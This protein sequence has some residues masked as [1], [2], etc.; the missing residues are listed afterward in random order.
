M[1]P[2]KQQA[3]KEF[4][5]LPGVTRQSAGRLYDAG[6]GSLKELSKASARD[7]YSQGMNRQLA[8]NIESIL[9][10]WKRSGYKIEVSEAVR[11]YREGTDAT[12]AKPAEDERG[13]KGEGPGERIDVGHM[14]PERKKVQQMKIMTDHGE[15]VKQVCSVCKNLVV[16]EDGECPFC[17][18]H[19]DEIKTYMKIEVEETK[20][21]RR[22][23]LKR[24]LKDLDLLLDRSEDEEVDVVEARRYH[25]RAT[26]AWEAGKFK[27]CERSIKRSISM[28][29]MQRMRHQR[30]LE[31]TRR[32][33][34][35]EIDENG[36]VKWD[37]RNP[38]RLSLW[39]AWKNGLKVF[40]SPKSFDEG[41]LRPSST[42]E[43]VIPALIAIGKI[44]LAI[45]LVVGLILFLLVVF[46]WLNIVNF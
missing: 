17:R 40:I 26:G 11:A 43:R 37:L 16:V 21:D 14:V 5:T 2:Q 9:S 13:A 4:I 30:E 45:V 29:E 1:E 38:G 18:D 22:K 32:R 24:R 10:I 28:V 3:V 15:S 27:E 20:E 34:S 25:Q 39:R 7:L 44:T 23:E 19:H 33:L 46:K 36:V 6:Y 12:E 41:H 31:K 42:S 35:G 8:T